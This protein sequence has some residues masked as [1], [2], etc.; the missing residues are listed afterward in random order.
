MNFDGDP[1]PTPESRQRLYERAVKW[2]RAGQVRDLWTD[3]ERDEEES[4]LKSEIESHPVTRCP[5]PG[6]GGWQNRI[7]DC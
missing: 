2:R 4:R 1:E 6:W 5:T 7:P 3:I